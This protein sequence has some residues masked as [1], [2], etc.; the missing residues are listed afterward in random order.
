MKTNKK[1][2]F[3]TEEQ[4]S[5]IPMLKKIVRHEMHTVDI[6]D[7]DDTSYFILEPINEREGVSMVLKV[8]NFSRSDF[9]HL[10]EAHVVIENIKEKVQQGDNNGYTQCL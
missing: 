10:R 7:D 2:T 8:P 6:I 4:V 1:V 3:F 9:M 5:K